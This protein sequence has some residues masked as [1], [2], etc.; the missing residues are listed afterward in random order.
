MQNTIAIPVKVTE[1]Y[2]WLNRGGLF[3]EANGADQSKWL[4]IDYGQTTVNCKHYREISELANPD[5][6]ISSLVRISCPDCD[7]IRYD[8]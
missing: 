4:E 5:D 7:N 3:H 8:N 1:T 6:M 2:A